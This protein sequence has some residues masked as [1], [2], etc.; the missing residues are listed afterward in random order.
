MYEIITHIM[1]ISGM[2]FDDVYVTMLFAGMAFCGG[3]WFVLS[4]CFDLARYLYRCIKKLL[5]FTLRQFR[6]KK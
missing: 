2:A 4:L 6:R 5:R 3:S 1:E